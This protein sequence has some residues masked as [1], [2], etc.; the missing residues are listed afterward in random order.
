MV[1][2]ESTRFGTIEVQAEK[3]IT[4]PGGMPG[5]P[6]NKRFVIL[7]RTESRPFLWFQS[8]D[9]PDLAFVIANPFMFKADYQPNLSSGKK[10][11]GWE[12]SADQDLKLYV[13]V[14]ASS[15]DP[16]RMTANLLGP[17]VI[18]LD[19]QEAMQMVLHN[20]PYSHRHPIF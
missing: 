18:N 6:E 14:N 10:V 20:A 12:T 13:I 19:R 9:S 16:D 5:F 15:G 3:I 11:M 17:L 8:I 4:M 7:E 1:Q 2:V